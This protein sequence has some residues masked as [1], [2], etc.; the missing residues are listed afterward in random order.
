MRPI[1]SDAEY[2]AHS[3]SIFSAEKF[4][5]YFSWVILGLSVCFLG[6]TIFIVQEI[7]RAQR[8]ETALRLGLVLFA[9]ELLE[10]SGVYAYLILRF[11]QPG[12]S[13]VRL[14]PLVLALITSVLGCLSASLLVFLEP[15]YRID[16]V[17]A[18]WVSSP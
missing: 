13:F 4:F 15:L 9:G 17:S 11:R 16:W 6:S 12:T 1:S 3:M 14:Y 2:D 8:P 10:L 5:G 18:L 7:A